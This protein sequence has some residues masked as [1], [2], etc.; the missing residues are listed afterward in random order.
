MQ[1]DG[2]SQVNLTPGV[3]GRDPA[4]S[5]D[6]LRIAFDSLTQGEGHDIFVMEADGSELTKV[7]DTGIIKA[8]PTWSPDGSK[9]AFAM[10]SGTGSYDIFVMNSDGSDIQQLTTENGFD[11]S[12][13]PDGARILFRST[14][15][16]GPGIYVMDANGDNEEPLT[17]DPTDKEPAWS[18]DM[19]RIVFV[20][21]VLT[22]DGFPEPQIHVMNADGSGIV[23]ITTHDS[24]NARREA[25]EWSPDGTQIVYEDGSR[26]AD[27]HEIY[28]MSADGT[29]QH[30]ISNNPYDDG[31]PA[32]QPLL[33]NDPLP[34]DANCDSKVNSIDAALVLQVNARLLESLLCPDAGDANHDGHANS[35]DAAL[36][37][38]FVAGLI[39]SLPPQG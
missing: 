38:Q 16:S 31:S 14:R 28:V 12:W 4:W 17:A 32:W 33:A 8:G 2:S 13:S 11:P 19:S 34:G 26:G 20:R 5:P 1:P 3:S 23:Q 35:I 25:P 6:G 7:T 24:I 10:V 27:E 29:N 22:P 36:I 18:P 21:R 37:L 15:L 9:I 39:S 30:N